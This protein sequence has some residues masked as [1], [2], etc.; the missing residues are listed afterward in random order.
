MDRDVQTLVQLMVDQ[1][2]YSIVPTVGEKGIGYP[3]LSIVFPNKNDEETRDFLDKLASAN[4]LSSSLLDR[5][6]VCPT[7]ASPAVYSKYN[8]PRCSAFDIG[9]AQ[10]IEHTRCGYIESMEKFQKGL[11]LICPNCKTTLSEIDYKKIGSSFHCNVCQSRFEA[12]KISHKCN[13]CNEVFTYKE[14]KYEAIHEYSL[15]EE[16]KKSIAKGTLPLASL[17]GSLRERGFQVNLKK[18]LVGKSGATH[19]FDIVA[20]R[21][22]ELIVANFT[23]EP[24]EE[25]IIGLFSKKYDIDPSA[26]L[27][28]ALTPPSKEEEA[29]AKAYGVRLLSTGGRQTLAEQV[30]TIVT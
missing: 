8:C 23:F 13:S 4:I 1:G 17:V 2:S 10:I 30:A 14:A 12:P 25:D 15:T 28:I 21:D 7:C 26:T 16:A 11:A 6:I 5:I 29:V 24:K 20:I 19:I 9:K 27:L 22:K 18:E 3:S